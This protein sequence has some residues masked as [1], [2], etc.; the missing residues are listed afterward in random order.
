MIARAWDAAKACGRFADW[1]FRW[2]FALY[3]CWSAAVWAVGSV[4]AGRCLDLDEVMALM[5]RCLALV[6]LN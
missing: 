6:G 2:L 4:H 1:V 5:G 3:V